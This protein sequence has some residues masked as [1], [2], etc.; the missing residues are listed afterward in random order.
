MVMSLKVE[1]ISFIT[2]KRQNLKSPVSLMKKR[3][4][5]LQDVMNVVLGV[6]IT[7][8]GVQYLLERQMLKEQ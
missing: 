4:S 8:I 5:C 6:V 1:E 2:L 7:G 3:Q